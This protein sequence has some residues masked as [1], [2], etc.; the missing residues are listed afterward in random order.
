MHQLHG[1]CSLGVSRSPRN[2]PWLQTCMK[3]HEPRN[4]KVSRVWW[5]GDAEVYIYILVHALHCIVL[6]CV[7]LRCIALRCVALRCIALRCVA[8]HCTAL[9]LHC[10][11]IALHCH[12]SHHITSQSQITFYTLHDVALH[13]IVLTYITLLSKALLLHFIGV[14]MLP[15][16]AWDSRWFKMIQAI[17]ALP[18]FPGHNQE[19]YQIHVAAKSFTWQAVAEVQTKGNVPRKHTQAQT[20]T[21]MGLSISVSPSLRSPIPCLID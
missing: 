16:Y 8:L 13:Y 3:L 18:I 20:A 2:V 7:A 21:K 4:K 14:I 12:P 15:V 10:I 19:G 17:I 5:F 6:H 11:C 9:H 1:S